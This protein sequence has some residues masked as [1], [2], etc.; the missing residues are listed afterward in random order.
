MAP[1][2]RF[3]PNMPSRKSADSRSARFASDPVST[4][5]EEQTSLENPQNHDVVADSTTIETEEQQP[6]VAPVVEPGQLTQTAE[7]E[8]I[9]LPSSNIIRQPWKKETKQAK[10]YL[11][12]VINSVT[13]LASFNVMLSVLAVC[14]AYYFFIYRKRG[15]SS[16]NLPEVE[17]QTERKSE[18]PKSVRSS[19]KFKSPTMILSEIR[20]N[21][22]V[23]VAPTISKK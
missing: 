7:Q 22:S 9:V 16:K 17:E 1:T 11:G 18:G 21:P 10:S 13:N 23:K 14:L 2:K 3:R 4:V 12:W 15:G 5:Q 19:L 6:A 8:T 20:K